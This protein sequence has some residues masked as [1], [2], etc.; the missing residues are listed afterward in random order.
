MVVVRDV[1]TC[2]FMV[3]V[4]LKYRSYMTNSLRILVFTRAA[5]SSLLVP[6]PRSGFLLFLAALSGMTINVSC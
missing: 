1:T 4:L 6:R 5:T 2:N 3:S